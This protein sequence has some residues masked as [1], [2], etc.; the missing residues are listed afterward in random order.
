MGGKKRSRSNYCNET[1]SFLFHRNT[2]PE[3]NR[4]ERK[5]L[6]RILHP[7]KNSAKKVEIKAFS[8]K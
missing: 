2:E 8:G 7:E 3:D 6:L 4:A 5:W 1:D